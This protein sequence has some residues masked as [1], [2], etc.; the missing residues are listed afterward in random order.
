MPNHHF[1]ASFYRV[2]YQDLRP[3]KKVAHPGTFVQR[4]HRWFS[5]PHVLRSKFATLD[6]EKRKVCPPKCWT[7][8]VLPGSNQ[9]IMEGH[10]WGHPSQPPVIPG[11]VRCLESPKTRAS[12]D[13]N[14]G[15]NH[16]SSQGI[17]MSR[18]TNMAME[19]HHFNGRYL[20]QTVV[21][22]H[23]HVSFRVSTFQETND[24][25]IYI[26]RNINAYEYKYIYYIH[27][28]K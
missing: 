11:E 4:S 16:R 25:Y 10:V 18:E 2:V 6:Q 23:Y 5:H 14:A 22:F 28:D 13:V 15:S 8:V 3:S 7:G 27:I 17:R 21:F 19:N 24:I 9:Y 1:W 26:C 20:C 12:G